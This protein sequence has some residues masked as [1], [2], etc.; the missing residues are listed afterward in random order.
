MSSL[1]EAHLAAG[2]GGIRRLESGVLVLGGWRMHENV[3]LWGVDSAA[4]A[5]PAP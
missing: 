2:R 1:V 4:T 5:Q 3:M